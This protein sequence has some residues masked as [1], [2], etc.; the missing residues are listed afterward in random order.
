MKHLLSL[1]LTICFSCAA[2]STYAQQQ[3]VPPVDRM[4]ILMETVKDGIRQVETTVLD[5]KETPSNI[6]ECR[7]LAKD[8]EDFTSLDGL[9][10][11]YYK[12]RRLADY[13]I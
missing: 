10:I 3:Q 9:V 5:F 13:K 7:K 6:G 1:L 11:C 12:G 8:Y 4:V 2:V